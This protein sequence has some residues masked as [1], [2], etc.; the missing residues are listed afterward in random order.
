MWLPVFL[1]F[2]KPMNNSGLVIFFK[3]L[4]KPC[5]RYQQ[6]RFNVHDIDLASG[7]F[8]DNLSLP[9]CSIRSGWQEQLLFEK[10]ERKCL[11]EFDKNRV[12]AGLPPSTPRPDPVRRKAKKLL[13]R[14][15]S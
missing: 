7:G 11:W 15:L 1:F 12:E 2:S 8:P 13:T 14:A 5:A 3:R 10:T 4:Q 9:H 6:C